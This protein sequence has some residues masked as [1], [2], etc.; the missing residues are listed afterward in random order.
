MG[1]AYNFGM[2]LILL[3]F[4]LSQNGDGNLNRSLRSFLD[5]Y[6]ENRELLTVLRDT[7]RGDFAATTAQNHDEKPAPSPIEPNTPNEKNRPQ[8]GIGDVLENYLRRAAL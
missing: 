3:V 4:L 2:E 7:L 6:R 5:F 8:D 1:T